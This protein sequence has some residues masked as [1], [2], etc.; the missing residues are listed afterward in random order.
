MRRKNDRRERE[1][2]EEKIW[3]FFLADIFD[4]QTLKQFSKI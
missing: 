4:K 2:T 1:E 3:S